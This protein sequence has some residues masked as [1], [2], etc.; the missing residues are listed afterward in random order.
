MPAST[1][2]SRART[3]LLLNRPWERG[4]EINIAGEGRRAVFRPV[5]L[6]SSHPGRTRQ[7]GLVLSR[8]QLGA[9]PSFHPYRLSLH[10]GAQAS[11]MGRWF[12]GLVLSRPLPQALTGLSQ[13]VP[14]TKLGDNAVGSP[15]CVCVYTHGGTLWQ[16]G[17][18]F[19]NFSCCGPVLGQ[20]FPSESPA[21]LISPSRSN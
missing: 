2:P 9:T 19:A 17:P 20:G 4:A 15:V 8:R 16:A 10:Q 12:W 13:A 18:T 6:A 11:P 1:P 21:V 5:R 3:W 7:P 14:E